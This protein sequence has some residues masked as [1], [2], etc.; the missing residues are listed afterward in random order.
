MG[1]CPIVFK[2]CTGSKD[3]TITAPAND[4][5]FFEHLDCL[6]VREEYVAGELKVTFIDYMLL[7][8]IFL[9]FAGSKHIKEAAQYREQSSTC[10]HS[11][12]QLPGCIIQL[13]G[14][15]APL[16]CSSQ[17]VKVIVNVMEL[18]LSLG[19]P[20]W[21]LP[22]LPA[23]SSVPQI[24]WAMPADVQIFFFCFSNQFLS[25]SIFLLSS[26]NSWH[27]LLKC[28][29]QGKMCGDS[30]TSGKYNESENWFSGW[31]CCSNGWYSNI[32][33]WSWL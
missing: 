21:H 24:M 6:D 32:L 30:T 23:V 18:S 17:P 9:H 10:C 3:V 14:S 20:F 33:D 7:T 28:H 25:R 29:F 1:S 27:L 13:Q 5:E 22:S 8:N 26:S 16:S 4:V 11:M 2:A 31:R 15:S 12:Q 19:N